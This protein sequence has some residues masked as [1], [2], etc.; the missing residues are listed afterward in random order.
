[1]VHTDK[2]ELTPF[3]TINHTARHSCTGD[4]LH[5]PFRRSYADR[6]ATSGLYA[7][8]VLGSSATHDRLP[9]RW[10]MVDY[11]ECAVGC[12]IDRVMGRFPP[13]GMRF[14]RRVR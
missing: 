9:S 5:S 4:V 7:R 14:P 1:M 2:I 11:L 12:Y 3:H 10:K 8:N 6:A 13:A